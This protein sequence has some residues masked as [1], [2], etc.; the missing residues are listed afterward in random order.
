[1]KL[2]TRRFIASICTTLIGF[3]GFA[4]AAAC[5]A[6]VLPAPCDWYSGTP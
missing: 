5:W 2:C 1:L 4:G 6:L 3:P